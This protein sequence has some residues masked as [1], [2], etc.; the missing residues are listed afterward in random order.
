MRNPMYIGGLAMMA[1]GKLIL[2][3]ISIVILALALFPVVHVFVIL[4]EEPT[5][6]RKFGETYE[7][8]CR[9]VSR[10]LPRWPVVARNVTSL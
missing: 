6:R 3:S 7:E 9:N 8:Y 10:W 2:R 4:Y 5:L 1:G